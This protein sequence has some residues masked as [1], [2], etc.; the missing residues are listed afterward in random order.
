MSR[1]D[2]GRA[3][4]KYLMAV[5]QVF[6]SAGVSGVCRDALVAAFTLAPGGA[7][8]HHN[9]Q[10]GL[11]DHTAEVVRACV[12]MCGPGVDQNVLLTAAIWHDYAK[13]HEYSMERVDAGEIGERVIIRRLP[14][15]KLVGHVVGSAQEFQRVALGWELGANFID[16]VVHCI[17]AHHGR[18]EWGSPV[19]PQT[20]E[21]FILHSADMMSAKGLIRK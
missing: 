13:I 19:E 5:A 18:R 15:S 10:G 12:D 9:W 17:L 20:L 6:P 21:A 8:H 14:Y 2:E 16:R 4:L 3:S 1:A 7:E 11:A